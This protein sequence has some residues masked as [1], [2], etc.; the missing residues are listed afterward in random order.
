V[1]IRR[2]P[3]QASSKL[4][5]PLNGKR[6]RRRALLRRSIAVAGS[7][8]LA[9]AWRTRSGL[10][11]NAPSPTG[12]VVLP[13]DPDYD[14]A[15]HDFNQR[16]DVYPQAIVYC[17][18]TADVSNAIGWARSQHLPLAVRAGGHSYEAF[19]LSP[20]VVVDISEMNAVSIDVDRQRVTAQPGVKLLSLYRTLAP[21]GLALSGGT[22]ETVGL[23][24][25]TLN[26][27]IG[28]LTRKWGATSDNL[29]GLQIV[30][31]QG[32]ILRASD[33][34][35][36]DLFWAC[37]GGGGSFGLVTETTLQVHPVDTVTVL[38]L[39]WPNDQAA[40]VLSAWQS[41]APFWPDEL[42]TSL[43][44]F[45]GPTRMA[46]LD[47]LYLGDRAALQPL[48]DSFFAAAPPT[49]DDITQ[50]SYL[51]SAEHFSGQSPL[52]YFKAKSNYAVSPLQPS[53][54]KTIV[55]WMRASPNDTATLEIQ[56]YGGAVNR[57]APDATAFPHRGTLFS[58]QYIIH[59]S[60]PVD[61]PA[62]MAWISDFYAAMR[63]FVSG[64]AYSNM[65][66]VDLED[67]QHAYYAGNFDRLVAVKS[68]YDPENIFHFAQSI[69]VAGEIRSTLRL[70]G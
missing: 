50:M 22:C 54:I 57:I 18:S 20:G 38:D 31:A 59:W 35:N 10:A 8:L 11:G 65:C 52:P 30:D 16:F 62:N 61:E 19:S 46:T 33:S 17:Q 58:M 13:G 67:W 68:T 41:L 49:K 70:R 47:G 23:G 6:L 56:A 28:F 45:G 48:L 12:R 63:P 55:Q 64:Y 25:L 1:K 29:L 44:I 7:A 69:P 24:G 42:T 3:N 39:A 53:A 15:R 40:T 4:N 60:D 36:P 51:E 66:D 43:Q 2:F 14:A 9:G 5:A 26:G 34:E 21:F 32:N 37:R 27:G